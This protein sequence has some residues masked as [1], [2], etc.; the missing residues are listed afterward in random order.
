[1]CYIVAIVAND[2]RTPIPPLLH[3]IFIVTN[4]TSR[5]T[6]CWQNNFDLMH[7]GKDL[8]IE[9][10]FEYVMTHQWNK[11]AA[12]IAWFK[13]MLHWLVMKI[14]TILALVRYRFL[15]WQ[16]ETFLSWILTVFSNY[17]WNSTDKTWMKCIIVPYV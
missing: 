7:Y 8:I 13:E 6:S 3:H 14:I 11:Q 17:I 15:K 10:V 2:I 1:M 12:I 4:V 16:R 9:E 5:Y